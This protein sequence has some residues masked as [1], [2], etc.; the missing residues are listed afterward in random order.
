[1]NNNA[2]LKQLNDI[3]ACPG[4]EFEPGTLHRISNYK[5]KKNTA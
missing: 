2:E 5:K 1:M 4:R 3:K